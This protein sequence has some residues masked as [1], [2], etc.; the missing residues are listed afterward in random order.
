MREAHMVSLYFT[1]TE[2]L[3]ALKMWCSRY[4]YDAVKHFE[5]KS[6][7]EFVDRNANNN[8]ELAVMFDGEVESEILT[9]VTF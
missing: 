1:E 5:R 6:M 2:V 9:G 4:K 7:M 3:E 8:G